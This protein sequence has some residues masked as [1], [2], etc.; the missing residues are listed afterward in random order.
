MQYTRVNSL[1]IANLRQ[2]E[3]FPL[4]N[5]DDN[6]SDVV[7]IRKHFLLVDEAL[8]LL[9]Y[10]RESGTYKATQKPCDTVTPATTLEMV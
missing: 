4:V 3:S 9:V 10:L 6:V 2:I 1:K 7:E 5:F 8:D